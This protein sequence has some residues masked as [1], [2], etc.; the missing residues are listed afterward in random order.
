MSD[1]GSADL[2]DRATARLAS[3]SDEPEGRSVLPPFCGKLNVE[4]KLQLG[5]ENFNQSIEE[6]YKDKDET[7]LSQ[8]RAT[9]PFLTPHMLA[10]FASKAYTDY[11]NRETDAQYETRLEL[12]DSWKLLTTTSNFRRKT[13]IL[14]QL[15]GT[16]SISRL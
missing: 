1:L 13:A 4:K 7:P 8:L 10:H 11:K 12:P 14:E 3:Q 15:I 2:Q 5:R 6:F 9:P 16:L